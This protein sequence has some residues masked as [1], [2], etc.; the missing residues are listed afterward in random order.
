MPTWSGGG[1]PH[2]ETPPPADKGGLVISDGGSDVL[3]NISR[4]NFTSGSVTIGPL[5]GE[6][7]VTA[8]GMTGA[9]GPTGPTGATGSAGPTGATG[10]TGTAGATGPTGSTGATGAG[11]TGPTGATGSTGAAGAT[12]PTGSTGA[13][14]AGATGPTGSA[15]TAGATG[16]TGSTGAT[17]ATGATGPTG[18]TGA[19][20][21]TGATGPTFFSFPVAW[22]SGTNPGNLAVARMP[23]NVTLTSIIGRIE[24]AEGAASTIQPVVV[25]S[26]TSIAAGGTLTTTTM[27]GNGTP[28]TDQTLTLITGPTLTAGQWLAITTAGGFTQNQGNLTATAT[29]T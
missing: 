9:T 20:G 28:F 26:G 16:P 17:G 25:N 12:G 22:L 27:N 29:L 24:V 3:G 19:T 10:S 7:N 21:A 4:L 14:G 13:T 23:A 2:N 11:A 8:A 1:D 6:A 15:G 5:P 18:V